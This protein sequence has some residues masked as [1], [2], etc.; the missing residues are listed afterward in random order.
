M[1]R[2]AEEAVESALA[3]RGKEA[4]FFAP[5][6]ASKARVAPTT[7]S[8]GCLLHRKEGPCGA[9]PPAAAARPLLD[10]QVL[11]PPWAVHKKISARLW[12]RR[13]VPEPPLRRL[14]QRPGVV[15]ALAVHVPRLEPRVFRFRCVPVCSGAPVLRCS[16]APV[17]QCSNMVCCVSVRFAHVPLS[18]PARLLQSWSR[19]ATLLPKAT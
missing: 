19:Q 12:G 9:V 15:G 16:G 4:D 14:V 10:A 2:K 1:A 3:K 11:P 7:P 8:P 13:A 6:N 5:Q 18:A 17:L